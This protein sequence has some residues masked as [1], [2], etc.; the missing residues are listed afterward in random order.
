MANKVEAAYYEEDYSIATMEEGRELFSLA[1]NKPPVAKS[2][3]T[4][5]RNPFA[6]I[7]TNR[8]N[9]YAPDDIS[10]TRLVTWDAMLSKQSQMDTR[11]DKMDV[12]LG[13]ILRFMESSRTR[14]PTDTKFKLRD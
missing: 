1:G 8:S 14:H 4:I 6:K 7:I 13:Q 12:A 9:N 3:T 2:T 5:S 11:L 10:V